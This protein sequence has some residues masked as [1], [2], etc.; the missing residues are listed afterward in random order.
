MV[1]AAGTDVSTLDPWLFIT[2]FRPP[3]LPCSVLP[4]PQ[5]GVGEKIRGLRARRVR[6]EGKVLNDP[7]GAQFLRYRG[8]VVWC[9]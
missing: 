3:A 2:R 4:L 1:W 5:K 9:V 8:R 6:R 7:I